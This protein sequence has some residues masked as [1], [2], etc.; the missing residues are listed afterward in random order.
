MNP[1]DLTAM[2]ALG[3]AGSIHCVQMCGPIVLSFGIPLASQTRARQ[4]A[5]HGCYHAGRIA[6][7]CLLGALAGFVGSGVEWIGRVGGV[8]HAAA[9][10]AGSIMIVAGLLMVLSRRNGLIQIGSPSILTRWTGRLLQS[11]VPGAK[12]GMGLLLGFLPCGLIYAAVL[13]AMTSGSPLAGAGEMLL[14]GLGTA[15]PLLF[16]GLFSGLLGRWFAGAGPRLAAVWIMAMGVVVLWRGM[17]PVTMA[18]HHH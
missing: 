1:L 6:T 4:A 8:A 9:I 7:Y 2:F 15:G 10:T 5:A 17:L 12:L 3:L 16:L 13:K 14:F 18:C 11:P